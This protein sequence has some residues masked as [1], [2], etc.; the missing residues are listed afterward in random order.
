MKKNKS[1]MTKVICGAITAASVAAF[2]PHIPN[3]YADTIDDLNNQ[4][5]QL[6]NQQRQQEEQQRQLENNK[7]NTQNEVNYLENQLKNLID[8]MHTLDAKAS[9]LSVRISETNTQLAEQNKKQQQQYD[10]MKLRIQYMY[11]NRDR[12]ITESVMGSGDMSQLLNSMEYYQKIYDYDRNQLNEIKSTRDRIQKL[13]DDLNKELDEV[14]VAEDQMSAKR[15]EVSELVNSKQAII[16]SL[17]ND[18]AVTAKSIADTASQRVAAEQSIT[19]EQNRI[20]AEEAARAEAARQEAERAAAA[21]RAAESYNSNSSGGSGSYT[22]GTY[23]SPSGHNATEGLASLIAYNARNNISNFP[24]TAGWCAAWVSGVYSRSG[25]STP[26]GNAIDYWNKWS[27]S[28]STSMDNIPVGA[29]VISSGAGYDGSIYGHIGIYLGGGMVAS[30]VGYCK[31]ES[32]QSFD[33][34]ATATCQGHRGY[35]GWV[36]P[37]GTALN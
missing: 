10:E 22:P 14:K 25:A 15:S 32:I 21:R 36:W 2:I 17:N 9:E 37:N 13:S 5:Q 7:A 34:S 27:Y 18:I 29:A 19:D 35:I 26:Y 20:A 6:E 28:G 30:N 3:I 16:A 33:A 24:S 31:I 12:S 8:E 23:N 1:F 4:K 11:E